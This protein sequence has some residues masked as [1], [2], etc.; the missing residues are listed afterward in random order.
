MEM[1]ETRYARSGDV[2]IAY[3]VVGDG[4]VDLVLVEQWFGHVEAQWD[5]PPLAQLL[6]RLSAFSRLIVFDK[7]GVGLSDPVPTAD[8]PVAEEWMDDLR[9]VLDDA[10]S[11]QAVVVS[12]HDGALIAAM[13]AATYPERVSSLVL[14]NGCPRFLEAADYPWGGTTE[15]LD[16]VRRE[17][18]ER[19]GRGVM[20][21]LLAP[22]VAR[23]PHVRETFA[24]FE[25]Q[26]A[27][28]GSAKAMI[29]MLTESDIRSILPLIQSPTLV[30]HR[31]DVELVP[32]GHG[33]YLA[34]EIEGARY[35]EIA[36]SDVPLWAG[37][38]DE[39]VAEIQ[40]FVTGERPH[41]EPD[42]CSRRCSSRTSW[43]RRSGPRNWVIAAGG[44][45]STSTTGSCAA[46]SS[47]TAA[48]R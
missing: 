48:E 3:Q 9:A 46:S 10:G 34:D 13:F 35:V 22:T 38:Q 25:R 17:V 18:D 32:S 43:A 42:G 5:L 30:L 27:S 45:C 29:G 7:R 16:R 20:A 23:D 11:D 41:L 6:E 24:R 33:R 4:P 2:H 47:A 14:V 1:P 37:D 28:P 36:G 44:R 15:Q 26:S 31:S 39:L 19:W 8:L 40:E 21:D 12:V